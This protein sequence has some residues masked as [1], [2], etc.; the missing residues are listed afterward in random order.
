MKKKSNQ[1]GIALPM[2]MIAILVGALV[3]P[4]FL[5]HAST[6][7]IGSR[8]YRS[9]LDAQYA[10]DAAAEQ[11]IWN[12]AEGTVTGKIADAGQSTSYQLGEKINGLTPGIDI[13]NA[14]EVIARDNFEGAFAKSSTWQ[15]AWDYTGDASIVNTGAPHEGLYHL[16]LRSKGSAGRTVNLS[17]QVDPY[18]RFWAEAESFE[19]GDS[20]ACR[21]SPDGKN[22][23]TLKTWG[24]DDADAFYRYYEF[25]LSA[26]GLTDTFEI[27]FNCGMDSTG[28]LLYIDNV[29]VV[30][31]AADF[32]S[33]ADDDFES[34]A[35]KGG[36]G[37]LDEWTIKGAAGITDA[38][39]PYGGK[40]HLQLTGPDGHAER[41]ADLSKMPVAHLRFW[42][43][44]AS[45]EAGE[46]AACLV[47]G[48]GIDWD[49]VYT[50]DEKTADDVYRYYDFDLSDYHLTSEFWIAFSSGMKDADDYFYVDDITIDAINAYC[51]T[52]EADG[53]VLKAA[54]DLMDGG[55]T[56]L[57]WWFMGDSAE[58]PYG[59][60][61]GTK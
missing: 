36:N 27:S 13:S 43:K 61:H 3:I 12:V 47:S 29:D 53:L 44:A 33:L 26:Y 34:G 50:W 31:P 10:C 8:S 4:A 57:C 18:L 17:K 59:R 49:T 7:L 28:D 22:W 38:G 25:P 9:A 58:N 21:V 54:V 11:A 15:G 23:T 39:K 5:G 19:P 46:Y 52:V 60:E 2:V 41:A 51:I 24:P 32:T 40:L 30:W 48:N 55:K 45:L 37:W 35:A 1:K 14:W 16:R 20:A 42:A 56:V 6:S